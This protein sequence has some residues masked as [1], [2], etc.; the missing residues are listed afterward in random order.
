MMLEG[1]ELPKLTQVQGEL[2]AAS[3]HQ[4]PADTTAAQQAAITGPDVARIAAADLGRVAA[5]AAATSPAA[6]ASLLTI[7]TTIT[8]APKT[9][10]LCNSLPCAGIWK[11][12]DASFCQGCKLRIAKGD[13]CLQGYCQP[14][15]L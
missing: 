5:P 13:G 11:H 6:A 15:W 8:E 7:F 12:A 9:V 2:D 4:T 10:C 14:L 1:D 3:A